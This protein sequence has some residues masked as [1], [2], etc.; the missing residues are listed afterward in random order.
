MATILFEIKP[1]DEIL[2]PSFTFVSTANAFVREKGTN[3]SKFFRGEEDKYTWVDIGAF[4]LPSE[5]IGT[6]LYTQ[7]EQAGKIIATRRRLFNLYYNLLIPLEDKGLMRLAFIEKDCVSNG[8]ISYIITNSLEERTRI[9]E[10]L[11]ER[12]TL[13]VFNYVPLHSS[14][15]G[16]KYS[17]VSS[18]T[19]TTDDLSNGLLKL[20]MYYEMGDEEVNSVVE[21]LRHFCLKHKTT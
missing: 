8:H 11:R 10:F 17:R 19:H 6:F 1:D 14:P 3:C 21:L 15:A 9:I 12:G 5:L 4:Y 20:P 13:A 18:D 7:L 16:L 2:M